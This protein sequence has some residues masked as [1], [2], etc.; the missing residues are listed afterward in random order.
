MCRWLGYTGQ[1][2][3]LRDLVLKPENSLVNQSRSSRGRHGDGFGFGW[4]DKKSSPEMFRSPEPI[5][6]SQD[7]ESLVSRIQAG[8]F[9]AHARASTT[10][11]VNEENC[12]PFQKENWLFVHNGRIV[13][14]QTVRSE[15]LSAIAPDICLDL[16]NA[17]DSKLMFFLALSFGLENDPI[18][19]LESMVGF[20]E[21]ICQRAG[22]KQPVMFS[23]GLTDGE[24]L[25]AVRYSTKRDSR[26]LF[27]CEQIERNANRNKIEHSYVVASEPLSRSGEDWQLLP[28]S[29]AIIIANNKLT[30]RDFRP[31][32]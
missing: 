2:I 25:I 26:T 13:D 29:T 28:E 1:P 23:A 27:V 14:F 12:H 8:S 4:Y 15:L 19:A 10:G 20:V 18:F 17:T 16:S 9:L 5:W 11:T 30:W 32:I 7:L 3:Y 31:V 21:R 6:K 22:I 24:K